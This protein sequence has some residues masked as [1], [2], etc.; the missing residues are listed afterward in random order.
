MKSS[1]IQLLPDSSN[2]VW[3][4]FILSHF[5]QL[6]RNLKTNKTPWFG[7]VWFYY[8][9]SRDHAFSFNYFSNE[10]TGPGRWCNLPKCHGVKHQNVDFKILTLISTWPIVAPF[11]CLSELWWVCTQESQKGQ[12]SSHSWGVC[13]SAGPQRYTADS[14]LSSIHGD[15]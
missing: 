8:L 15:W 5:V 10:E 13:I 1:G 2:S 12:G 3:G 11:G 4:Q 6:L 14:P 7:L 9:D